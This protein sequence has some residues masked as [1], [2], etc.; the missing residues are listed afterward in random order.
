[1]LVKVRKVTPRMVQEARNFIGWDCS[2][3]DVQNMLERWTDPL[4][5]LREKLRR[6]ELLLKAWPV[7]RERRQAEIDSMRVNLA[8]RSFRIHDNFP[9]VPASILAY[10]CEAYQDE[11][12]AFSDTFQLPAHLPNLLHDGKPTRRCTLA[13]GP[14][15]GFPCVL[16]S[17]GGE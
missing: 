15:D 3:D 9:G 2:A 8:I 14:R 11:T 4:P 1:M 17:I 10:V 13:A 12:K 16:L 5:A 6:Q 7:D